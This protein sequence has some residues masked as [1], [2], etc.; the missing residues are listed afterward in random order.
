MKTRNT[1]QKQLILDSIKNTKIHPT[2]NDLYEMVIRK[3]NT[4]G[5][6][7]VYRNLNQMVNTGEVK[8]IT[9]H[10]N[11][12]RYDGNLCNH[13]HFICNICGKIIDL[14][15]DNIANN[16]CIENKY[17]FKVINKNIIYEGI[18]EDCLKK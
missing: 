17:N 2:A 6:S 1:I 12:K 15:K 10:N 16:S 13:D 18:C 8:V 5:K 7:T 4:I 9:N 11:S 3:D 14:D